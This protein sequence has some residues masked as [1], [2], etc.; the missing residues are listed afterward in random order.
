MGVDNMNNVN[1]GLESLF[2]DENYPVP[3]QQDGKQCLRCRCIIIAGCF[4]YST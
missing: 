3:A 1:I 4:N 2:T